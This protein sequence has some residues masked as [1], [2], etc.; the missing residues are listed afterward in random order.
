MSLDSLLK[1]FIREGISLNIR[2]FNDF[3]SPVLCSSDVKISP[4]HKNRPSLV[5]KTKKPNARSDN[6]LKFVWE[7]LQYEALHGLFNIYSV[8]NKPSLY[9]PFPYAVFPKDE[10]LFTE[11]MPGFILKHFDKEVTGEVDVEDLA[12]GKE[13]ME[14]SIAYHLGVLTKI[15]EIEGIYHSD[16]DLR[17]IIFDAEEMEISMIDLENT[18]YLTDKEILESETNYIRNEWFDFAVKERGCD[19]SCLEK[20]FMEGRDNLSRPESN[21][22]SIYTE[23]MKEIEK[24]YG[25]DIRPSVGEID[26]QDSSLKKPKLR[27][28]IPK[29][30]SS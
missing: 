2:S 20:R 15:K 29:K 19:P 10:T 17:H 21:S 12:G 3:E 27:D 28:Y 18:R 22:N 11:F 24:E 16:F 26:G 14:Y 13:R 23:V 7:F 6:P 30:C 4:D 1:G 8:S 9:V 25:I 5:K